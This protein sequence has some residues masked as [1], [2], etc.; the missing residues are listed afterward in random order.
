MTTSDQK[1]KKT[2]IN[3][4]LISILA[5]LVVSFGWSWFYSK[6]KLVEF[7][8]KVHPGMQLIEARSY[9]RQVGLKYVISSRRDELGRFRDLVTASGVM[10]RYVCEIQHDG[11]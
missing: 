7:S 4:C 9:A 8:L 3:F 6:K 1:N 5:L 10:G 11:T 2:L